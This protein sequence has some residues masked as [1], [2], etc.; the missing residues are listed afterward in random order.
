MLWT[1][2]ATLVVASAFQQQQQQQFRARRAQGIRVKSTTDENNDVAVILLAGGVGSRMKADRPKQFLELQG[3]PVLM[4]SLELFLSL[5]GVSQI[6][7]VL[8][9]SYRDMFSEYDDSRLSF[10][11]PGEERQHS[12]RNGF[13]K[14]DKDAGLICI[15]DAARPL[16]TPEAIGRVLADAREHGASVLGVPVKPTIKETDDGEFV[17]Q[18]LERSRL[19]E[20]QTPQVIQPDLLA[21]GFEL[22]DERGLEVTDDVS[23][24]EQIPGKKVKLTLGDYSNLK[25]TTP[26]D[27]IYANAI[28]DQRL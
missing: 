24:V 20:V 12:V 27:M 19:W 22:V 15:H 28:L 17:L 6:V 10:A 7:V 1:I 16:V 5:E 3:K 25:L 9:A 2:L 13:A 23:I 4:H 18:T 11:D 8:D 21:E 26:D 14:C